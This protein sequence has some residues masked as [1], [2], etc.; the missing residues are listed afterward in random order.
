MPSPDKNEQ[1]KLLEVASWV[2]ITQGTNRVN[3]L[4]VLYST[5]D[6]NMVYFFVL[7]LLLVRYLLDCKAI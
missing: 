4:A 1:A 2:G 6:K 7:L 5:T 3:L